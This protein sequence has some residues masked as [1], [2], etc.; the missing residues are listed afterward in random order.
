MKAVIL[1]GGLGSRLKPFTEVIPKPLLPI[2]EKAVLE[3]QI[4]HLKNNGFDHIFLATN[5]KS[6][7]I[8]N[9]FGNGSKY[10]VKL[11][12]S[13]EE[14][15]LGTAGP[16]KLLQNQLNNEPFL[17]MNGDILT[18]LPY[19]KLYEF[20]CSKETLLTIATKDIYTPFQ[21]GN[22]HTEGDFVTGIEEKPNI[23]TTILA[24]IY[25][26]KPEILNLIP[27]NTMY[28]MDKLIID[29]LERR[30]P[31]SHYPIQEYWLDIGQVG[32]YEKAQEIYKEH[33][34]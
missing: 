19:R 15:P 20:A 11:S 6:E 29:M 8:E 5:Y 1:S 26:F 7:Y 9:F 34:K 22:I 12:I 4:E 28:G 21:F 13:K 16:V 2:G 18:L 32:D 14:K 30:L 27:D 24:G 31:I 17:V 23:K 3:I 25:I 33:F 10:G